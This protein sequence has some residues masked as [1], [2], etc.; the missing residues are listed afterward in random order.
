VTEHEV[1]QL[2]EQDAPAAEPPVDVFL[3]GLMFFDIVFTG[4]DSPPVP[5]TEVWAK[6]LG[7]GPGGIS[8]F[9]VALRRLGLTTSLA[10]AFGA[11]VHGDL[12]HRVLAEAEGVDL[13]R[14]RR[15]DGWT[16]PVTVALPY[17]DDRALVT[18]GEPP[19]VSQDDLVGDPPPSRAVLIH[20][21]PDSGRWIA[22]SHELGSLVF[23][24]VGWDPSQRW[25]PD[26]L[27]QLSSCHAFLPNADEAMGYTRTDTPAEALTR[28]A[29]LMPL[30]VVTCGRDGAIAVDGAT[31]VW[32]SVPGLAVDVVDATGAGDVF[33][34]GLTAAT[35]AG[36][37][38]AQR[39][40]FA[41]LTSALSL[42]RP[43]GATAAPGWPEIAAWWR[44]V[45][46]GGDADVRRDYGFLDEVIPAHER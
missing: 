31:G 7:S 35:L 2:P 26:L 38:L 43:G 17:A 29:D 46:A 23:A 21:A 12:C 44:T 37:P 13:S 24:D 11:D 14:S 20:L 9:A 36:W 1:R 3:A 22:R 10:T 5:G 30:A 19:P 4:L 45:Q 6:G 34:A 8:N 27:D 33:G 25:L 15:F 32:A 28:L 18:Y 40:R 42:Q 16:T 41:V 39:L